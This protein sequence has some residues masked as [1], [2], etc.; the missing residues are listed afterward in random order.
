VVLS[1]QKGRRKEKE[2]RETQEGESLRRWL[3]VSEPCT[4]SF[5]PAKADFSSCV[6]VSSA[7]MILLN[8]CP[9]AHPT[10]I[11][12]RVSNIPFFT[13]EATRKIVCYKYLF[14]AQCLIPLT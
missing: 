14:Y 1:S 3:I 11:I 9:S 2:A 12:S 13:Y 7:F 6:C 8:C 5:M 10:T 4:T